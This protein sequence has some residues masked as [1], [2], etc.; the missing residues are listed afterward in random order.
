MK[1]K[2]KKKVLET[3]PNLKIG[4]RLAFSKHHLL[5]LPLCDFQVSC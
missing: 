5:G 4:E 2:K 1:V 3:G